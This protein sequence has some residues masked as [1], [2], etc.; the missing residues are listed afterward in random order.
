MTFGRRNGSSWLRYV[1]PSHFRGNAKV[2]VAHPQS[3]FARKARLETSNARI[4]GNFTT[5]SSLELVTVN[6][7]IEANVVMLSSASFDEP[8]TQLTMHTKNAAI[9]ANLDLANPSASSYTSS[10]DPADSS[11]GG[12]FE[13]ES[14]TS[15]SRSTISVQSQPYSSYL[16][17]TA[18]TSNSACEV[19]LARQFSGSF[20]LASSVMSPVLRI[21]SPTKEKNRNRS[22]DFSTKEKGRL[23]GSATWYNS[24]GKREGGGSVDVSTSVLP[25]ILN[26]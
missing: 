14:E 24:R 9:T 10:S 21:S 7:L 8:P 26:L 22:I 15:N 17:L 16:S 6:A 3:L 25:A 18:H 11:V 4:K 23:E 12:N 5:S 19:S 20:R 1:K 13:I 2:N